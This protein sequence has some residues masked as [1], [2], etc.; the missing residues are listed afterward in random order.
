MKAQEDRS[1][2][3]RV[4][5]QIRE[6]ILSGEYAKDEE[7]RETTVGEDLGVS[8]TPVR[9]A[10]RQLELEGLVKIVPNKG[11]HVVGI[12]KK[13]VHD[14]YVM[15]SYLEGLAARWASEHIDQEMLNEMEEVILLSEFNLNKEKSDQVLKLDSRFHMLLYEASESR[16]L[17]HV[18]TDYHK[19]VQNARASSVATKKRAKE[20]VQEHKA[21]LEAMKM[22]DADRA[23]MLANEHIQHVI[24][25]LD[26]QGYDEEP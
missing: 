8:R 22:G 6:R 4:F 12:S 9:E 14:I 23:E 2:R 13:D 7:L 10:L 3:E 18:L 11:A 17:Q 24:A 19:F 15:R 21:I 16:M 26:Q 1:P 20:S 25:N 5:L